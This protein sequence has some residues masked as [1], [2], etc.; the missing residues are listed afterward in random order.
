MKSVARAVTVAGMVISALVGAAR[1]DF[2]LTGNQ[3]LDVTQEHNMG[4]LWDTSTADVLGAGNISTAYVNNMSRLRV[5][6][7]PGNIGWMSV[8]AYNT[9]GVEVSSGY[10][11]IVDSYDTSS[12][13][14]SGGS[15][16]H[17]YANNTSSVHLSGGSVGNLYVY[18]DNSVDVSGGTISQLLA[19]N[20][21]N[22]DFSDGKV[23]A[24]WA[25]DTSSVDLSGGDVFSLFALGTS[26]TTF[27]GYDFTA[28]S[29]L[30]VDGDE[31]LG[32]GVLAGRWLD[33]TAW[34]VSIQSHDPGATILAIPEP[35]TLAL[36]ALGGIGMLI[37]R[38]T[39]RR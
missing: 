18:G 33:G 4:I 36:L 32:T 12:V 28:T 14:I 1:A 31:V 22:V 19:Y 35:S 8:Y 5:M 25:Y 34:T 3:H 23:S 15:V 6:K 27:H 16:T 20:H 26:A 11:R 10:V 37:R 29:G 2:V 13:D 9:S 24:V 17:V 21:C 7:D 39:A 30:T 38:R